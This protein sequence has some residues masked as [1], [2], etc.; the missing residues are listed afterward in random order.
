MHAGM[1]LGRS[2]LRSRGGRLALA[3]SGIGG[4]RAAFHSPTPLHNALSKGGVSLGLSRPY[5][6]L[7]LCQLSVAPSLCSLGLSIALGALGLICCS[8]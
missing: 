3:G 8:L 2:S 7:P 6:G 5:G 4:W 1:R